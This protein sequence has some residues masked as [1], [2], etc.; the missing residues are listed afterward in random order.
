LLRKQYLDALGR[1]VGF[2]GRALL[3]RTG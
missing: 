2:A 1:N 3:T